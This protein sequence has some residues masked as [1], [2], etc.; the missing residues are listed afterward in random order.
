MKIR[1]MIDFYDRRRPH[2]VSNVNVKC[3]KEA[4]PNNS[5][6]TGTTDHAMKK[7]KLQQVD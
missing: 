2:I 3:L 7:L 6:R 1:A 5:V 4:D